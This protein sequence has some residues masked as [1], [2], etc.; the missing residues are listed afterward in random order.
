LEITRENFS[1]FGGNLQPVN[2]GSLA[3]KVIYE[4][5]EEY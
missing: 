5:E 2:F 4:K 3:D 1:S